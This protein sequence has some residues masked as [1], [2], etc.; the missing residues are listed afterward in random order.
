VTSGHTGNSE[1]TVERKSKAQ[2]N[3]L[4]FLLFLIQESGTHKNRIYFE[5]FSLRTVEILCYIL[6]TK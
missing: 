3:I 5:K 4:S 1:N 6:I 2:L